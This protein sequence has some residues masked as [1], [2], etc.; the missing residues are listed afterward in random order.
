MAM[1]LAQ[2]PLAEQWSRTDFPHNIWTSAELQVNG[3]TVV[4]QLIE[5]GKA[6]T[7]QKCC[8]ITFDDGSRLDIWLDP[9]FPKSHLRDYAIWNKSPFYDLTLST[10]P[11]WKPHKCPRCQV[12]VESWL[13]PEELVVDLKF[14]ERVDHKRMVETPHVRISIRTRGV[15]QKRFGLED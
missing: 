11:Q 14:C 5:F 7:G 6:S 3:E 8:D 12:I 1:I 2:E 13:P 9:A 15:I 10:C 4:P